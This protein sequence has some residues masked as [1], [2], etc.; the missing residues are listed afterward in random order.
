MGTGVVCKSPIYQ[1]WV[2]WAG[3]PKMLSCNLRQKLFTAQKKMHT[4]RT[5]KSSILTRTPGQVEV[6]ICN[7]FR[8]WWALTTLNSQGTEWRSHFCSQNDGYVDVRLLKIGIID[9]S[10]PQRET[11]ACLK[12]DFW[13]R[14]ICKN[15]KYYT[16][17]LESVIS[18]KV[19]S[20]SEL[21]SEIGI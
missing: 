7:D 15:L 14:K 13:K 6:V 10:W 16:A 20:Y 5:L 18:V 2:C 3:R 8:C 4:K 12:A 19:Y 21:Q 17:I 11:R 9:G 1:M